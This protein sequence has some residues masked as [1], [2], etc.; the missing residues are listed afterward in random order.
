VLID[1][2][3]QYLVETQ[4]MCNDTWN[5]RL[6]TGP[7]IESI[8]L[9]LLR[10][11][12]N[13][14]IEVSIETH[15]SAG[16]PS[17][18]VTFRPVRPPCEFL[19][20]SLRAGL[21]KWAR[22]RRETAPRYRRTPVELTIAHLER[23][24]LAMDMASSPGEGD[25]DNTPPRA[26]TPPSAL[27][28]LAFGSDGEPGA[29]TSS[30]TRSS[31]NAGVPSDQSHAHS[32]PAAAQAPPASSQGAPDISASAFGPLSSDGSQWSSNA[33]YFQD[34]ASQA[35]GQQNAGM[36]AAPAQSFA[37]SQTFAMPQQMFDPHD[38]R[39]L[40]ATDGSAQQR[41]AT[42]NDGGGSHELGSQAQAQLPNYV[43]DRGQNMAQQAAQGYYQTDAATDTTGSRMQ[44]PSSTSQQDPLQAYSNAASAE[45]HASAARAKEGHGYPSVLAGSM[46]MPDQGAG[47]AQ[48]GGMRQQPQQQQQQQQQQSS[49]SSGAGYSS[50]LDE[51]WMPLQQQYQQYQQQQQQSRYRQQ[52]QPQQRSDDAGRQGRPQQ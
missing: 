29:E 43:L 7:R 49:D 22:E 4:F 35:F 23:S 47:W 34:A 15:A 31:F 52:Q 41:F 37:Q 42:R 28:G 14:L 39:G 16:Q 32:A 36:V 27:T 5:G 1:H 40:Q 9:G 8:L 21:E 17:A 33:Q 13:F 25:L 19:G 10:G 30:S 24:F 44:R 11:F 18:S 3:P 20:C 46:A 51:S 48:S 38:R 2:C 6:E 26:Q 45:M 50:F 12:E